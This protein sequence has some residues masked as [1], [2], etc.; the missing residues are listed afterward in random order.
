MKSLRFDA[1]KRTAVLRGE[2]NLHGCRKDR[3][4]ARVEFSL[5]F[6]KLPHRLLRFTRSKRKVRHVNRRQN[7]P[8]QNHC[9]ASAD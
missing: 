7:A 6:A 9:P 3:A 1:N 2:T 4:F 8:R 5:R